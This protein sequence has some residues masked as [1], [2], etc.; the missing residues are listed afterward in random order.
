MCIDLWYCIHWTPCPYSTSSSL[1]L[2]LKILHL[3]GITLLTFGHEPTPRLP[4]EMSEFRCSSPRTKYGSDPV[5][6]GKI[7]GPSPPALPVRIKAR[8]A[9]EKFWA[10][11]SVVPQKSGSL[12]PWCS[13]IASQ[14]IGAEANLLPW[15]VRA[16][17]SLNATSTRW[18]QSDGGRIGPSG[19]SPDWANAVV[20]REGSYPPV[21]HMD[22]SRSWLWKRAL[23][24]WDQ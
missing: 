4:Q 10:S 8:Y 11:P 13:R 9:D 21:N 22:Y 19:T 17:W 6:G 7:S 16:R 5:W 23:D 20:W 24:I 1:I 14:D 2:L 3:L 15:T 18:D 12:P